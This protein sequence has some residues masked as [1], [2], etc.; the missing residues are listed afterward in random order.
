MADRQPQR[1]D[2][3]DNLQPSCRTGRW[4]GYKAMKQTLPRA[5]IGKHRLDKRRIR[6]SVSSEGPELRLN[7][8]GQANTDQVSHDQERDI[9]NY[10]RFLRKWKR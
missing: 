3:K 6:L 8:Y 4:P 9:S 1:V 2:D 10:I 5:S 7:L